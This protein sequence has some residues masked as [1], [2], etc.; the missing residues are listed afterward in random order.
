MPAFQSILRMHWE[1]LSTHC[2]ALPMHSK[3]VEMHFNAVFVKLSFPRYNVGSQRRGFHTKKNLF[4][5]SLEFS[6]PIEPC[7]LKPNNYRHFLTQWSCS[8]QNQKL[9]RL[10]VFLL[11]SLWKYMLF[12]KENEVHAPIVELEKKYYFFKLFCFLLLLGSFFCAN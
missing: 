7:V 5:W 8:W 3:F 10:G 6:I 1:S 4:I 2:N 11:R 9:T 12:P